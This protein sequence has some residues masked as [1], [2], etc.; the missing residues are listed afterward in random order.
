MKYLTSILAFALVSTIYCQNQEV[1]D[2]NGNSIQY[3]YN[4]YKIKA[5][6]YNY[7]RYSLANNGLYVTSDLQNS[8]TFCFSYFD[9]NG[10]PANNNECL[11]SGPMKIGD[12]FYVVDN[13]TIINGENK[14]LNLCRNLGSGFIVPYQ[15]SRNFWECLMSV[16]FL[17]G[18]NN[19][20]FLSQPTTD[21]ENVYNNEDKVYAG[22][23]S[24]GIRIQFE[25]AT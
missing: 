23:D 13:S 12:S 14:R 5:T 3:G 18:T 17:D 15:G 6:D 10:D 4:Y 7:W 19:Y 22:T 9:Q 25:P 21:P 20:G 1:L 2:T 11:G 24:V 16:N 8:D